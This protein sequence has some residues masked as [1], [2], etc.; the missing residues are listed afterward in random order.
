MMKKITVIIIFCICALLMVSCSFDDTYKLAKKMYEYEQDGTGYKDTLKMAKEGNY[1]PDCTDCFKGADT[2]NVSL[3]A[4][5]CEVDMDFAMAIYDNGADIE[6]SNPDYPRT[7]LLAALNGNRNN[8]DIVYWLID[9]GAD[10][11]AVDFQDSCVFNYLRYW[12]DNEQTQELISYFKENCD[13]EYLEE[14]IDGNKFCSWDD[15]WDDN[16]EFVFYGK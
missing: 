16:G 1:D 2:Q 14:S 12:D 10:I 11:N 4:Y 5:A 7:P 3:F 9:E 8:I 13:M 15:M 6:S